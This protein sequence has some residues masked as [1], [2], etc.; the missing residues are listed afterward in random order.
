PLTMSLTPSF[1]GAVP[2]G[3]TTFGS[4]ESGPLVGVF[5]ATVGV[6]GVVDDFVELVALASAWSA[7]F[8]LPTV[9][10]LEPPEPHPALSSAVAAAARARAAR[11]GSMFLRTV[12]R[13]TR[14]E[15]SGS[16]LRSVRT[17]LGGEVAVPCTRNP[18]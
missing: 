14:R 8:S 11:A 7:L 12:E 1:A 5:A 17:V 3:G 6:V 9:I 18:L 2:D 4:L 10:V 13:L 15:P 16:R